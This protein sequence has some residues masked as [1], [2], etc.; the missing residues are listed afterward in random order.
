MFITYKP[1]K[2]YIS[3]LDDENKKASSELMSFL[4]KEYSE[5]P[6]STNNHQKWEGGYFG[7]VEDLLNMANALYKTFNKKRKMGF[8][9]KDCIVVFL[10]HDVEKPF[11]YGKDNEFKNEEEEVIQTAIIKKYGFKLN[12]DQENALKYIHGEEQD[13]SNKTRVM[14]PLASFCH[15]CDNMSARIYFNYPQKFGW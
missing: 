11:K 10:L 4:E 5:V 6:G 13:Y 14:C 3:L 7:H 9:F 2:S 8:D 15:V 12:E 1:T